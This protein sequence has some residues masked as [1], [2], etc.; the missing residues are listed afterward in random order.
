MK[1]TLSI[2]AFLAGSALAGSTGYECGKTWIMVDPGKTQYLGKNNHCIIKSK[3]DYTAGL[4]MD[5]SCIVY[6]YCGTKV[7]NFGR[8]YGIGGCLQ[9]RSSKVDHDCVP[10]CGRKGIC[11]CDKK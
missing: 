9:I 8:N 4:T 6:K 1:T 5:E 11:V 7:D 10:N 2:V 3:C